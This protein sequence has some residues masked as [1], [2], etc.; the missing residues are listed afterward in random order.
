MQPDDDV[1][2]C[3]HVSLRKLLNYARRERPRHPAQLADCLNAG[4]GCGWCIPVLCRI[5][6]AVQEGREFKSE[7]SS[8][9]YA[10]QRSRYRSENRPR[11]E[12]GPD[13]AAAEKPTDP[14][15]SSP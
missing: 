14:E 1:C 13:S 11:H 7:Q 6:Q 10:E 2:L 4:T 5:H 3:F 8:A 12:F 15:I 9:D